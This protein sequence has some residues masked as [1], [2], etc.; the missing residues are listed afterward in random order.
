MCIIMASVSHT[1]IHSFNVLTIRNSFSIRHLV[2]CKC[3][4]IG[5]SCLIRVNSDEDD[6]VINS[7]S[8]FSD[9]HHSVHKREEIFRDFN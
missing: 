6:V 9:I 1:H 8:E 2:R 3:A 7:P 4:D 5:Q